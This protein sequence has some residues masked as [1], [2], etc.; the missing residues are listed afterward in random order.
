MPRIGFVV[1]AA[2]AL[3]GAA[4]GGAQ[5]RAAG[6]SAPGASTG[7]AAEPAAQVEALLRAGR[8]ANSNARYPE[9]EASFRQAL[10][11]ET[12]VARSPDAMAT[13]T[14]LDLALNVSN[15]G[16]PDEAAALLRRAEPLVQR[17]A[18]RVPRARLATY[19]ALTTANH[20]DFAG[21]LPEARD[22]AAQWRVLS[23]ARQGQEIG[24]DAEGSAAAE[25]AEYAN[26]LTL[27]ARLE[28]RQ[29]NVLQAYG[30]ASEALL[31]LNRSTASPRWW[32]ADALVALGEVSIAQGRVSAAET[33]FKNALQIRQQLFANGVPTI[34]VLASLGRAYQRENL[35]SAA[36][37]TY[38]EVFRLARA[39]P[40]TSGVFTPEMLVP[41]ASAVVATADTLKTDAERRGLYAEAFDAFQLVQSP[42]VDRTV[43]QAAARL[44]AGSP[45]LA[46]AIGDLQDRQREADQ[47]RVRLAYQQSLPDNERSGDEEAQLKARIATAAAAA[48]GAQTALNARFP[49]YEQLV[50]AHPVRLDA[51]R[52]NLRQGEGVVSYLVGG[53]RSFVQLVTRDGVTIAAVPEGSDALRGAVTTLR[54]P[55]EVQGGAIG[56]FNLGEAHRLY[57]ELL[58]GLGAAL[59]G[60]DHLVVV[61]AGP[62]SN[63]P[64]ALLVASPVEGKGYGNADWLI[65]QRTVA[66]SPSIEAL[67]QLRTAKRAAAPT[68]PFLGFGDPS[69]RGEPKTAAGPGTPSALTRLEGS[70]LQGGPMPA[71]TLL[72][73]APLPDTARELT[74]VSR[75]LRAPQGSLFMEGNATEA[76]LRAQAI[77]DYRVLYFATH[78]LLPG[79]LRCQAEPGLVLTPPAV[80]ATSQA[81]D[82]LLSSSE[83]AALRLNADLVVL[84]ACNT[85]AGD[86]KQGGGEALSGLAEAFFHAGARNMVVSHWQVPSAAT[87]E[88][89]TG[90]FKRWSSEREATVGDALR[91]AQLA[92]VA[93]PRT[94][95]PFFWAAFV[96]MGDGLG[97]PTQIAAVNKVGTAR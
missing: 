88:L 33:Y 89:M 75:A 68:R 94:A 30:A 31:I 61:P 64:F 40:S 82:G 18:S 53:E 6:R 5:T 36:I 74:A 4:A 97:R 55:L 51:L 17:D 34:Q 85:A 49:A 27:Q 15:Q 62:L 43:A 19:R 86:G 24:A 58:G 87:T 23:T 59:T 22:A 12:G 78:G 70:C 26:A 29:D 91:Q 46:A 67:V 76:S 41:F 8:T 21:A 45:E 13:A 28:L 11:L 20:G 42:V 16:R 35:N 10:D 52:A 90:L 92:L 81:T 83:I 3:Y 37:V 39:L 44:S 80:A 77:A 56:E 50:I 57:G 38:R 93:Q 71:A 73:L 54:R 2:V 72:A 84:S 96:T 60:V 7:A 63:L 69:L 95:H 1:A 48:A 14:L 32:R 65:R 25:E 79:E 66:Y 9:A 47:A